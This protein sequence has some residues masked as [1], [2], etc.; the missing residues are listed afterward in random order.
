M[1][2][3][4][5]VYRW[6]NRQTGQWYVGSH[7]G[8]INDGYIGSGLVF[9][10][11]VKAHGL[12]QFDREILYQGF[13]FRSEEERILTEADAVNDSM[14]YNLKNQAVG[15]NFP[16][17]LNGMV[18]KGHHDRAALK[19]IS[20]A[21]KETWGLSPD[22]RS[23][24]SAMMSGSNNPMFGNPRSEIDRDRMKVG[25][26]LRRAEW[27]FLG[28]PR[29]HALPFLRGF[30]AIAKNGELVSPRGQLVLE[31]EDACYTLPP[32]VRFS[33]FSCRKLNLPY[34]KKEFLWYLKGDRFDTSIAEHAAL[35]KGL[36]N[37]DGSV[38]SNYGQYIFTGGQFDRVLEML[39]RDRDSRQA[40]IIILTADHLGTDTA[41]IPC[42]YSIGFRIRN[43]KLNMSV[44]MRSQD[45]IFGM[46]ND[47]PC[48]SFVHEMMLNALLLAY[49]ELQYGNYHHT[50]DSLHVYERHFDML[51]ELV[52]RESSSGRAKTSAY[53]AVLCPKISGPDEVTFLRGGNFNTVP[54]KYQFTQWLVE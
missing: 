2:E 8:D 27:A 22:R 43:N 1:L 36:I 34:I 29:S 41:D 53:T 17:D 31:V 7:K 39:K 12:E 54:D 46:G 45:A 15:G 35:W 21:S 48:F 20:E 18:R 10:K 32:Y 6:T 33:N 5:F 38:N 23:R 49:P 47:A 51:G 50:V 52:G 24:Q 3:T 42:T 40:V 37:S 30:R 14:S 4:G 25:K 44:H 16:G 13:D 28:D 19:K 9:A 11:V 26:A